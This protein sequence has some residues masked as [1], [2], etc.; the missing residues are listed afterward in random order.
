MVVCIGYHIAAFR[1]FEYGACVR[2]PTAVFS[3]GAFSSVRSFLTITSVV[4]SL[5]LH[6]DVLIC[7]LVY[8]GLG[9][10]F[11]FFVSYARP[12]AYMLCYKYC[13]YCSCWLLLGAT[14]LLSPSGVSLR[15]CGNAVWS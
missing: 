4:A 12:C 6:I 8:V 13:K 11:V 10:N 9:A 2:H 15:Q 3:M 5:I 7:H 14:G 1:C